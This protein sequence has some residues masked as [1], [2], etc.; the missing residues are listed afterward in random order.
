MCIRDSNIY[1]RNGT[2][3]AYNELAYSITIQDMGDYPRPAD[4]NAML[5][6]LVTILDRRGEKVEGKLEIAMDAD[7]EMVFTCSSDAAKKRFLLNFYGLSSSD[8]LDDAKGKY[9]SDITAREAFEQKKQS[10]G[11]DKMKDEKG[12]ALVLP[13]DIALDIIN[14]IYTMN[15]TR[16]QKYETTTVATNVTQ[17]TMTEINENMPYLKGVSVEQSYVR[18]YMDSI[19]FCLLYTSPSPRDA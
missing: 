3:L 19:Y 2:I 16:Y 11:L 12:N 4:R 9:P 14:I 1:D 13:D 10:Y 17:E 6:R 15:L 18:K 8:K 5:L 7:G